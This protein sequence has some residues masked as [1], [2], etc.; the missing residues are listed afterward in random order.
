MQQQPSAVSGGA[1]RERPRE[2]ASAPASAHAP[3]VAPPSPTA[4]AATA[5]GSTDAPPPRAR[6]KEQTAAPPQSPAPLPSAVF[7]VIYRQY[8]RFAAVTSHPLFADVL[9]GAVDERALTQYLSDM[10]CVLDGVTTATADGDAR[11]ADASPDEAADAPHRERKRRRGTPA[12]D[13]SARDASL[14]GADHDGDAAARLAGSEADAGDAQAGRALGA[15]PGASSASHSDASLELMTEARA[16]TAG[17][18]GTPPFL[19]PAVR[20]LH[21]LRADGAARRRPSARPKPASERDNGDGGVGGGDDTTAACPASAPARRLA[22]SVSEPDARAERVLLASVVLLANVQ[23]WTL[24]RYTEEGERQRSAAGDGDGDG[25][26]D[27]GHEA[28]GAPRWAT[29]TPRVA[30]ESAAEL[31]HRRPRPTPAP[32]AADGPHACVVELFIDA[33]LGS[34]IIEAQRLLDTQLLAGFA[35]AAGLATPPTPPSPRDGAPTSGIGERETARLAHAASGV[36]YDA[37]WQRLVGEL[38]RAVA[39]ALADLAQLLDAARPSVRH[40]AP[41]CAKCERPGHQ[42]GECMFRPTGGDAA[43]G[44]DADTD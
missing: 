24:A 35:L 4:A 13:D 42:A 29:E 15:T 3:A 5:A 19:M 34:A 37:R 16:L 31:G 30:D 18:I 28:G 2:A 7:Q 23:A 32:G 14:N 39:P 36:H 11:H 40:S 8:A 44:A 26:G 21:R 33:R 22:R 38:E 10:E 41:V 25:D 1:G 12:A 6:A 17:L 9:R 20:L 43:D 27:D